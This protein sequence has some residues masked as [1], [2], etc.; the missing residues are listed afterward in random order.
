[1]RSFRTAVCKVVLF[2]L[3]FSLICTPV[4]CVYYKNGSMNNLSNAQLD[5]EKGK[6]DLLFCGASQS[7]QGF[8]PAVM[9]E[10]LGCNSFNISSALLSMEGRYTMLRRVV[11]DN[12]VQTVVIDISYDCL[13]R[14][15]DKDPVVGDLLLEEHL[16]G[17]DRFRYFCTHT[18]MDELFTAFYYVM[19]TG[20]FT[21]FYPASDSDPRPAYYGKGYWGGRKASDQRSSDA[22]WKAGDEMR[23]TE[24]FFVT[25]EKSI[26]Y[27]D[28]IM[29]F[30]Q[31]KG[32]RVVFVTTAYPM[33]TVCRWPRDG[34]LKKNLDLARQYGC[35]LYDFN[36][37]RQK[38]LWFDDGT[39]YCDEEHTSPEGA[40][41]QTKLLSSWIASSAPG[42]GED[43][44]FYADYAEMIGDYLRTHAA[45]P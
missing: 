3:L 27:L 18:K 41:T 9:D 25:F 1:M 14:N 22:L 35:T 36:L 2:V 10:E 44:Q 37:L 15:T 31:E 21:I 8:I 28:K 32:I 34:L 39:S 26:V 42:V 20:V 23:Q 19:H 12:P 40:V 4:V 43:G 11:K 13:K 38:D 5:A 29:Q 16:P 33:S 45:A 17:A 24:E 30:C 6:I 7:V